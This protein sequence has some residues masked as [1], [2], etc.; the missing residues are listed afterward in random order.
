MIPCDR[1]RIMKCSAIKPYLHKWYVRCK[2]LQLGSYNI[3]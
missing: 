2:Q 3:S 1:G